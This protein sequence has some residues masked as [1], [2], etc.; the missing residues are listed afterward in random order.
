MVGQKNTFVKNTVHF[1]ETVKEVEL[2]S[3]ETMVS[4]DIKVLFANV[5]I[6]EALEVIHQNLTKDE[7]LGDRTAH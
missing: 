3:Y 5:P 2:M 6:D 4:F 1:V 7:T